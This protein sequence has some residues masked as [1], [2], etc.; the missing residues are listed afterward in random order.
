M[1][2]TAFLAVS[3]AAAAEPTPEPLW[4]GPAPA[5]VGD[6]AANTPTLTA[7][8]PS[9]DK[10]VG[11]AVVVCP[12][13]G[14]GALAVDHEGK[15]VADWLNERGIAAFVLKY[16]IATPKRPAP[17][18]PAPMLDV[19]RAIRTVRAKAKE[20][21]VRPD[22]IGVWGFSAGGHLASTAATH[23]DG[24]KADD[25]DSI[26]RVSCRPDFTILAY[27]VITLDVPTT[28]GGSR[29]NLLGPDPDPALVELLSNDRRVTKETPPTFL[30]H[31]GDDA[32]VPSLNSV[33]FYAALRKN[34][35]PAELHIYE[36][37]KHGVGLAL[38]DPVLSNWPRQ[39]EAW[40]RGRG[41]LAPAT[42]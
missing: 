2:A 33:A 22:R 34:G 3:F 23:F 12:G 32:A 18:H 29:R 42:P 8:L 30:F 6:P 35:V 28:H 15:Q 39:L 17:L 27:P 4:K 26:E 5:S 38:N 11:T 10:A 40:L 41:L 9:K 13:G 16:R 20:I 31:T 37:G 14:Y 25:A 7:Y 21:G 24:G 1:F 19:Q 36:H